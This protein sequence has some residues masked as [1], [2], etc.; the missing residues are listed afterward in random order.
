MQPYTRTIQVAVI[1]GTTVCVPLPAPTFGQ[2]VRLVILQSA[3]SP[4]AFTFK[5]LDRQGASTVA[6]DKNTVGG[7][8]TSITNKSGRCKLTLAEAKVVRVG[9]KIEVKGSNVSEYNTTH[10]VTAVIDS[11]HVVTDV[12]YTTDETG[13]LW[14]I[15]PLYPPTADPAMHTLLSSG[16]DSGKAYTAA[17]GTRITYQNRDNQDRT[18]R[19]KAWYLYAELT[20]GGSGE[21]T[22][23]FSYTVETA[24]DSY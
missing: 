8:L 4:A 6:I 14:Q 21:Q 3:G 12:S 15:A 10:T 18:S 22:F 17:A 13:G 1:G 20:A 9:S 5:I 23:Q 11:I 2:I 19:R 16:A 7:E 24:T